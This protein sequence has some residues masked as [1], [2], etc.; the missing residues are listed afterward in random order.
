M[1]EMK[2]DALYALRA[3]RP[4]SKPLDDSEKERAQAAR[5]A[6]AADIT[7]HPRRTDI[8]G[9]LRIGMRGLD[10]YP[11]GTFRPDEPMDRG[12]CAVVIEDILIRVSGDRSLATRFIGGTAPFIDLQADL[13]YY[14]AVML[15]TSRGI[16]EAKDKALRTFAPLSPLT[17]VEALLVIRK[18]RDE[19]HY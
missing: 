16:M 4:F 19:L 1:E 7:S 14:N 13:P 6:T 18:I 17:G 11:D 3:P 12:S 5:P 10:L 8:E 9:I 15:A 2:I